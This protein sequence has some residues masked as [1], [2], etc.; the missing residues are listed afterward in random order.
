M[1][2]YVYVYTHILSYCLRV[3]K[4]DDTGWRRRIGC[5]IFIGHFLKKS[6]IISGSFAKNDL[7]LLSLRHP[8][9][10][11]TTFVPHAYV[12][13][14]KM[15]INVCVYTHIHTDIYVHT[16]YTHVYIYTRVYYRLHV[17]PRDDNS[18]I[19]S[20]RCIY[21]YV[22]IQCT[23]RNIRTYMIYTCIHIFT[24]ILPFTCDTQRW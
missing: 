1:Y 22:Y 23:Y 24:C 12:C 19:L 13:I 6:P 3:M 17:I 8:V 5:L 18:H 20:W 2:K 14:F 9:T 15:Y 10:L 4:K 7:Q 16:W 21:I 11:G